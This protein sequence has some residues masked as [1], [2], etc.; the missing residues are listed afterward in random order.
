MIKLYK[1]TD[2]LWHLGDRVVPAGYNQLID[3]HNGNLRI[4][5]PDFMLRTNLTELADGNGNTFSSITDILDKCGDFFV[6]PRLDISYGELYGY[7][8]SI[9]LS[10]PTGTTY[11]KASPFTNV[12]SFKNVTCS[13]STDNFAIERDG[14]YKLN[15]SFS[16]YIG[17]NNVSLYTSVFVNGIQCQNIIGNR[18]VIN[19]NFVTTISLTGFLNLKKGDVVD[20]RVR[21]D[22][23]SSVVLT[24]NNCNMN[25]VGYESY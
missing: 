4:A 19:S 22:N 2:E 16:S 24:T 18:F 25:I 13:S 15:A 14:L 8:N 12:G 1:D 3:D 17:T 11:T 23:A 7:D 21:H 10:I 5:I 20:V 6:N 9:T